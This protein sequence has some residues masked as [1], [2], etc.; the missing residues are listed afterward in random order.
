MWLSAIIPTYQEAG[1]VAGAVT[2]A[3]AVADEVIVVDGGSDDGTVEIAGGVGAK[4]LRAPRGRGVQLGI[5]ATAARGEVLLFLHADARLDVGAR[6]AIQRALGDP[7]VVGGNFRLRFDSGTPAAWLFSVANDLRRRWLRIYY[8]DS[9][10]FVRKDIYERIGG[11]RPLPLFE[12]YDFARRL[13][14][15]GRTVYLRDVPVWVSTRRFASAPGRTLL[16]WGLLQTLYS[17]GVPAALLAP[18]Y[19]DV[20]LR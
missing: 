4:L 9:A 12:D 11:F 16:C 2:A 19:R 17:A 7:R 1:S 20:R 10:I 8:G 18:L 15:V 3:A 13:E 5:G 6:F 14:R